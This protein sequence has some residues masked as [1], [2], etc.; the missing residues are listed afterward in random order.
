MP[1]R[2][3][4]AV[5]GLGI[6]SAVRH[7]GAAVSACHHHGGDLPSPAGATRPSR[8]TSSGRASVR[9]SAVAPPSECPITVAGPMPSFSNSS[10]KNSL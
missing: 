2:I 1:W 9:W 8:A 4:T 6:E 3:S 7:T 5:S 10:G